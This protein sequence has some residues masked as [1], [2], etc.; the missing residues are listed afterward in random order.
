VIDADGNP[1]LPEIRGDF[2]LGGPAPQVPSN[3]PLGVPILIPFPPLPVLQRA[4]AYSV[5]ILID[6]RHVKSLSFAVA[7]PPSPQQ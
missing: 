5:E 1:I 7:H 6:D 2:H 4:G 3:V